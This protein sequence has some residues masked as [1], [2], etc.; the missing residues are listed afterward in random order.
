VAHNYTQMTHYDKGAIDLGKLKP[1]TDYTRADL[2]EFVYRL[3]RHGYG[4]KEYGSKEIYKEQVRLFEPTANNGG[5]LSRP[6]IERRINDSKNKGKNAIPYAPAEPDYSVDAVPRQW[7]SYVA[8]LST[9]SEFLW[10]RPLTGRE[11]EVAEIVGGGFNDPFGEQVDLIP[12]LAMVREYAS[13]EAFP[14]DRIPTEIFD[15]YFT[16]APWKYGLPFYLKQLQ[17]K[18][19]G[20]PVI[21]DF[22]L[23]ASESE[24]WK[25][26][27]PVFDDALRQLGLMEWHFYWDVEKDSLANIVGGFVQDD[28]SKGKCNWMKIL[29]SNDN[30]RDK[31]AEIKLVRAE[32]TK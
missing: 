12:Q 27:S 26:E 19:Q 2:E 21:T 25:E 11:A 9:I 20:I 8:R 23:F 7:I 28:E 16:Y 15:L 5:L 18:A 3:K 10:G 6:T 30:T 13:T 24:G 1:R 31:W 17:P 29:E 22:L 14:S 32:V 4:G